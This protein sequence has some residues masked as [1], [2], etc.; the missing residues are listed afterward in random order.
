M[1]ESHAAGGDGKRGLWRW[2]KSL[3]GTQPDLSCSL[4]IVALGCCPFGQARE[5]LRKWTEKPEKGANGGR[6]PGAGEHKSVLI[7]LP[8]AGRGVPNNASVHNPYPGLALALTAAGPRLSRRLPNKSPDKYLHASHT[9]SRV[10]PTKTVYSH[11]STRHPHPQTYRLTYIPQMRTTQRPDTSRA[12]ER[13]VP[14]PAF[15]V[16]VDT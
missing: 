9:S 16:P 13:S 15:P 6:L 2:L 11:L 8:S 7:Q 5:K 10:L 12:S 3:Q 4:S 14:K 1:R